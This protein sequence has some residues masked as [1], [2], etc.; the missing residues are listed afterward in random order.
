MKPQP[1]LAKELARNHEVTHAQAAGFAV[2]EVASDNGVSGISTRLA[3]RDQG[4]R[5]IATQ[6][7]R[8]DRAPSHRPPE[9]PFAGHRVGEHRWHCDGRRPLRIVLRL[10]Q[11]GG[12][13]ALIVK[14]AGKVIRLLS[15]FLANSPDRCV[16]P[17]CSLHRRYP[18]RASKSI[19]AF[20]AAGA[21]CAFAWRSSASAAWSGIGVSR[22]STP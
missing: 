21:C 22:I 17:I 12:I 7:R 19:L 18:M 1:A 6:A 8:L 4:E 13:G 14:F 5:L 15:V 9:L 2:D 10:E 16:V 3:E 11:R 20:H